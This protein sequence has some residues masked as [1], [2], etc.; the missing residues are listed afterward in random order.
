MPLMEP[1]M[2]P[3][4]KHF[5]IVT[6]DYSG[7]G[8]AK[9][10]VDNGYECIIAYAP[11]SKE[12]EALYD[13]TDK[14][15]YKILGKGLAE[16]IPLDELWSAR[17]SY[18]QSY[19]LFDMNVHHDKGDQLR[20]EG[21]PRVFGSTT[22][23]NKMEH[24]REFGISLIKKAGLK[25]PDTFEFN[26]K[27]D[28]MK[29]LD[30]NEDKAY[31]FKPN[32]NDHDW[33]TFVPDSA[34]NETANEE[35]F[36]YLEALPDGNTGGFILQE[37]L[38]GTEANFEIWVYKGKPYFAICDLEC[39]RKNDGDY[40][41]LCGGSQDINFPVPIESKGI[42]STVAKLLKL[43]EFKDY[44]GFIDMNIIVS[45]N[46]NYF[47]EFCA[48]FGY[49][50]HVTAFFSLAVK[51]FPEIIADMIDGKIE[52]FYKNF[53]YGFAAG[54]TMY[55]NSKRKG[56]PF[57]VPEDIEKYTY[58]FDLYKRGDNYLTAGLSQEICVVTAHGFT[59]MD[60]AEN[61]L[62]SAKRISFP[63]RALRTDLDKDN[64]VSNPR[65][66]YLALEAMRYLI[67]EA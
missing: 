57:F 66:R 14:I 43:P 39:K 49:P 4:K 15:A 60:A 65:D 33:E 50:E 26:S 44:T 35:L 47:L 42:Q 41:G 13:D 10:I 3:K 18:K 29:F 1:K 19:W 52:D 48:R 11:K 46:D 58:F 55:N 7:I 9:N 12:E 30:E 31:V 53:K 56:L 67:P 21:F 32:E 40:G 63:N 37:R 23:T 24:D 45:N 34:K 54:I 28:G 17:S 6:A 59:I 16:R 51:P 61:V 22:F 8:Y 20:K 25:T 2:Q 5:I 62:S 64:Y 38:D 36:S 27:E